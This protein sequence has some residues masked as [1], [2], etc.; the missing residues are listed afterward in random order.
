MRSAM[1]A[2]NSGLAAGLLAQ[3]SSISAHA[4]TFVPTIALSTWRSN[5]HPMHGALW[6]E[7]WHVA[8]REYEQVIYGAF[9]R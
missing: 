9:Q 1:H 3:S 7:N 2:D 4:C 5:L 6:G 8:Q